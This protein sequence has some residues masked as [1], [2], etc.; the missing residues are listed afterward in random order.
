LWQLLHVLVLVR[1]GCLT[2][3][4]GLILRGR[5]ISVTHFSANVCT[6]Q[7]VHLGV[8]AASKVGSA[9]FSGDLSK[10]W[11]HTLSLDSAGKQGLASLSAGTEAVLCIRLLLACTSE[12]GLEF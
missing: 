11:D 10:V 5:F 7:A 6:Q 9:R 12:H 8:E 3:A 4:L 2:L 1:A